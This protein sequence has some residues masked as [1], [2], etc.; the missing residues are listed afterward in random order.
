MHT[1]HTRINTN[2]VRAVDPVT[3]VASISANAE[4]ERMQQLLCKVLVLLQAFALPNSVDRAEMALLLGN[5]LV[6]LVAEYPETRDF[7][8]AVLTRALWEIP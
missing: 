7:V 6:N 5:L 4:N 3:Q 2:R 8:R 1:L